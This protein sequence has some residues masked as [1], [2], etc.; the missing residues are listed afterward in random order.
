MFQNTSLLLK[1][2]INLKNSP[3]SEC[4]I[5]FYVKV[6]WKKIKWKKSWNISQIFNKNWVFNK[7]SYWLLT[8]IDI[9][10]L[11]YNLWFMRNVI[12]IFN[13]VDMECKVVKYFKNMLWKYPTLLFIRILKFFIYPFQIS[14]LKS[15]GCQ[16]FGHF[17]LNILNN[18][19]INALT[20]LFLSCVLAPAL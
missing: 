12:T 15:W 7:F 6:I 14:D 16:I 20:N 3:V 18:N 4:C 13:Y 17:K 8:S 5:N 2:T 19:S 9:L 1:K 11:P 10:Y